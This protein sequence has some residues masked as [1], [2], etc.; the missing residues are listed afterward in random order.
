MNET[1]VW[2]KCDQGEALEFEISRL[3]NVGALKEVAKPAFGL[4]NTRSHLI[5][6]HY[7][8]ADGSVG[9]IIPADRP[10]AALLPGNSYSTPLLLQVTGQALS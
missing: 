2:I 10:V 5:T 4:D 9:A 1:Y 8:N 7:L 6:F 3:R